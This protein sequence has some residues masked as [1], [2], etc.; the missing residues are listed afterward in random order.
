MTYFFRKA[1]HEIKHF[2]KP[3]EYRNLSTEIEG[4]LYYS[5]RILPSDEHSVTPQLSDV[6]L[7]LSSTTFCVPLTYQLPPIAYSIINEVHMHQDGKHGGIETILRYSRMISYIIGGRNLVKK[8]EKL[9]KMQNFE[10]EMCRSKDGTITR[11][12]VQSGTSLL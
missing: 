9:Y 8:D 4:I 11:E 10:K 5:N 6:M 2:L 1:T 3:R 12:C 7:D